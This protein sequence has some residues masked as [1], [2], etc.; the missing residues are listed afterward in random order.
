M[1]T[2]IKRPL[3][4][5]DGNNRVVFAEFVIFGNLQ[6]KGN[7]REIK[8]YRKDIPY[9]NGVIQKTT[10]RVEK[11]DAAKAWLN[12]AGWQIPLLRDDQAHLL[13]TGELTLTAD[14]YYRTEANDLDITL[15]LD[16]L[17]GRIYKN[18]RQVR[19]MVLD[20]FIDRDNPRVEVVIE[21]R[22]PR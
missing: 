21:K 3:L 20:H 9:G 5:Y 12:S 19:R 22:R 4:G 11:S 8:K 7:G 15:L 1:N 14:V 17:Q 6:Q 10:T 18:D 16:F 13:M 2:T